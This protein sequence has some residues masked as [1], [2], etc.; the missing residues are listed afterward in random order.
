MTPHATVSC[1]CT[2]RGQPELFSCER[3]AQR[4]GGR[5]DGQQRDVATRQGLRPRSPP[6]RENRTIT[7]SNPSR[8]SPSY[9]RQR[10]TTLQAYSP[11]FTCRSAIPCLPSGSWLTAIT[12][13]GHNK[14]SKCTLKS[15]LSALHG[16][17][18]WSSG[19]RLGS[20]RGR[21]GSSRGRLGSIGGRLDLRG[22]EPCSERR[23]GSAT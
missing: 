23:V 19:G 11:G 12:P 16:V 22:E 20:I 2:C 4:R 3:R 8:K 7:K 6:A 14:P 18:Y 13:C 15:R 5:V 17:Q 10:R 9:H 1:A 21:L